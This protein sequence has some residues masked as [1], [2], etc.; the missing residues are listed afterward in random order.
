[1][2]SVAVTEAL[3][4]ILGMAMAYGVSSLGL[5]LAYVNY[6]KRI[7]KADKV[8]SSQAWAVMLASILAVAVGAGV[9]AALAARAES[10]GEAQAGPEAARPAPATPIE[11]AQAPAAT[12]PGQAG[13]V[14]R[15]RW[16]WIGI[17]IPGA[18]FLLATWITTALHRRFS[19]RCHPPRQ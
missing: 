6:R 18:I 1:M 9:V 5:L 10:P 13:N 16:P 4:K 14:A 12:A 2:G 17:V 15:A 11:R 19:V 3:G 8:M 7:V